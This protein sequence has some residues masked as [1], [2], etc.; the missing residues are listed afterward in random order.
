MHL[1]KGEMPT[2]A[3]GLPTGAD[4]LPSGADGLPTGTDGLIH[5]CS[6]SFKQTFYIAFN[7]L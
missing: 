3:N 5:L 7:T 1:T 2:V 6:C 4:G